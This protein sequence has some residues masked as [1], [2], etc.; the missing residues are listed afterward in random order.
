MKYEV[1]VVG[2]LSRAVVAMQC[3]VV[4]CR[5]AGSL[6]SWW[7]ATVAPKSKHKV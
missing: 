3:S 1:A 5:K 2:L 7:Y 4:S 6:V